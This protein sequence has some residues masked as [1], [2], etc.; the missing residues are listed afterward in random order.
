MKLFVL[1]TVFLLLIGF[2]SAVD[3]PFDLQD[4]KKQINQNTKIIPGQLKQL[5][6]NERIN[7][8]VDDVVIGIVTENAEIVEIKEKEIESP[9][10]LV[11]SDVK[12]V[13]DLVAG[14]LDFN[15]ALDE[16][17]IRY[18]AVDIVTKI[19]MIFG[20][21]ARS[22]FSFV[23]GNLGTASNR[24][25]QDNRQTQ[26]VNYTCVDDETR[27]FIDVAGNVTVTASPGG[28]TIQSD[29]CLNQ[30]TVKEYY[31][32]PQDYGAGMLYQ[33]MDCLPDETCVEGACSSPQSTS[34]Q[35]AGQ[36]R[37]MRQTISNVSIRGARLYPLKVL[38]SNIAAYTN[39]AT[40][41]DL[42][43]YA[44]LG[45]GIS[46]GLLT[47]GGGFHRFNTSENVTA[48]NVTKIKVGVED[49]NAYC[50]E[51]AC[52]SYERSYCT[53]CSEESVISA[54][55]NFR[56]MGGTIWSRWIFLPTH[57][58]IANNESKTCVFEIGTV[59]CPGGKWEVEQFLIA[60]ELNSNGIAGPGVRIYWAG[61]E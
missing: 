46:P 17:L 59:N 12:T 15:E 6:G 7:A 40:D 54:G 51:R 56:C 58:T 26:T 35:A 41:S 36:N 9:T 37:G 13:K 29:E 39:N 32:A 33:L 22:I 60:R 23:S 2:A 50:V 5:F 8:Y 1:L 48:L 3:F 21:V 18:E 47:L 24:G 57:C 44:L 28:V 19:K 30:T 61:V 55:G 34:P 11:Y 27:Q 38:S 16:G 42:D 4:F 31:C 25:A 14:K 10:L 20:E 43:S 45:Y 52:Q 49:G 53:S